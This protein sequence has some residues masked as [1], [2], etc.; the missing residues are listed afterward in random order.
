MAEKAAPAQRLP[1]SLPPAAGG[2]G[3]KTPL[4]G[5]ATRRLARELGVDLA[6]VSGSG[7]Q[8]RIT[9]EDVKTFVRNLASG[10]VLPV[11]VPGDGRPTP[12]LPDFAQW[13]PVEREPL[14]QVRRLTAQQMSLSWT[15]VPHVTQHDLADVTEL[16][17]FRKQH[18]GEPKLTVTAFAL[19]A[20]AI[21]LKE[22]PQVNSSLDQAAGQLV[23][24]G[25]YHIGVAVDTERGLL[26]P[27]V[28]DVDSKSI[29]E[30]AKEL[31]GAAE[32]ARQGKAE[33]R[34]GTFT[35][36]NLGGIGG[37]A[38]TPIVNYPEVAILGLS[39][40]RWEPVVREGQVTPRLMLPLSLSYDHRVVDGAF[41]R[42]FS[43]KVSFLARE[44]AAYVA[45]CLNSP[46]AA[47]LCSGSS[48]GQARRISDNSPAD[49]ARLLYYYPGRKEGHP[50]PQRQQGRA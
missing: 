35:I 26:V 2:D 21:A 5:P 18:P 13:G 4:A 29:F 20:A 15:L 50:S 39:R 11:A 49:L 25:Y 3:S 45:L 10:T 16:E 34:G 12:Q 36:T 6:L 40:S 28:R 37:T 27:V 17:T 46:L 7:R 38:F 24:K 32:R 42:P 22:Y 47:I 33:M 14:S 41:G 44:S 8:G 30:L 9:E 31:A 1:K 19:K 23:L 43:A 48:L